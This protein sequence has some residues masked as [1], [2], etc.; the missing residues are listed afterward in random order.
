MQVKVTD[1]RAL[2]DSL[3]SRLAEQGIEQVEIKAD[4]Y[5]DIPEVERYDVYRAPV[6]H[7]VGQLTD[8][9][10][11]LRKVLDGTGEPISY[12]LVWLAAVLRAV[13]EIVVA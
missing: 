2:C 5:W 6:E 3:L 4:Y 11:E 13:G 10:A 7:V 9:W 12:K 8:D 1:L